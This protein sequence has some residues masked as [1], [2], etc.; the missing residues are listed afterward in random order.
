MIHVDDLKISHVDEKVVTSIIESLSTKYGELMPLTI[1][2]DKIYDY[3]GMSFDYTKD[4]QVTV[5]MYQYIDEVL[6]AVPKRYKEGVGSAAPSP[7]NMYKIRRPNSLNLKLFHPKKRK[8]TIPQKHSCYI[9]P[10]AHSRI[11]RN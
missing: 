4:N 8:S 5:H 7:S 9:C 2:R 10:S 1:S 3:L 6:A 11:Y